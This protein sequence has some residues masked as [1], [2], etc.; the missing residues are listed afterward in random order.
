MN[1]IEAIGQLA[2]QPQ[3]MILAPPARILAFNPRRI[4]VSFAKGRE[5]YA[6]L[7]L[8]DFLRLDWTV[9]TPEELATMGAQNEAEARAALQAQQD[10]E[11]E[12]K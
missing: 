5:T 12:R 1:F 10:L 4:L 9:V 6:H 8:D 7:R 3:L 11:Y 2:A